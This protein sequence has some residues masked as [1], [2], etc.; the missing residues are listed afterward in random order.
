MKNLMCLLAFLF[1]LS[2]TFAQ[3]VEYQVSGIIHNLR[4]PSKAYLF[5]GSEKDSATIKDGKFEFYG[6]KAEPTRA[7]L[8]VIYGPEM[9]Y[10]PQINLFLEKGNINILCDSTFT[11]IVVN[12]GSLNSE[13]NK[14]KELLKP[15][16]LEQ[17]ELYNNFNDSNA[18]KEEETRL[19][20]EV[21]I[22]EE[23]KNLVRMKWLKDYP[24]SLTSLYAIKDIAGF[25]PDASKVIELFNKLSSNIKNSLNGKEYLA[26]LTKLKMTS[27]GSE[28]VNFIKKD[29]SGKIVDLS[30]FVG[31][32]V[33]LDFWGS[34]CSPCRASHPHLKELYSHYKEKGFEIIGI[35]SEGSN[36]ERARKDWNQAIA[37]DKIDWIHILNDE[38]KDES[39]VVQLYSI[40][41]FPTK[42]LLD[43]EGKIIYR[44]VGNTSDLDDQLKKI[45]GE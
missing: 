1:C 24:S 45:L 11:D 36:S 26:F 13:Y 41:A 35:A 28:A 29:I 38:G 39:D 5:V 40:S 10:S 2:F 7:E 12:G 19:L 25:S 21:D 27:K 9:Q 31:K 16:D 14:L 32:Y 8:L 17:A 15:Y 4:T 37:E 42:V 22:L 43:K 6:V 23:K 33:L 30:T 34:W 44:G 18:N 3:K 20:R